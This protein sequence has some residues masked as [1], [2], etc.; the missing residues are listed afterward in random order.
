MANKVTE[1]VIELMA[2]L[3]GLSTDELRLVSRFV[4]FLIVEQAKKRK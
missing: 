4:E 1:R 3:E 2:A